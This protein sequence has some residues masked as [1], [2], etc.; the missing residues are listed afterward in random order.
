VYA[1]NPTGT[2][3]KAQFWTRIFPKPFR[4]RDLNVDDRFFRQVVNQIDPGGNGRS[5]GAVPQDQR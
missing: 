4:K 2:E 3:A 5:A 1:A